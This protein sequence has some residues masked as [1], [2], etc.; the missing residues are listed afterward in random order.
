[1][2]IGEFQTIPHK[3][4]YSA[5]RYIDAIKIC[6]NA[7]IE[8]VII[9]S[10]THVWQ[11]Q[12]GVLEYQNRLGGRYQDWMKA[13]PVYQKWLD[14]I[15]QSPAHIICTIRKKQAYNLIQ[16]GQK[17]K[18][19]KAGL[20]DQIRDGFDFEMTIALEIINDTHMARSAKDRTGLFSDKP[21]FIVTVETGKKILEWCNQGLPA[22]PID[23]EFVKTI[24]ACT[25]YNQ[26]LSLY[27]NNPDKKTTHISHFNRRKQEVAPKPTET[28]FS[29]NNFSSNGTTTD[30]Q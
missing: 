8:V 28:N 12:G 22:L 17:T 25:T 16:D 5:Q 23:D 9:D 14:A 27:V 19:E 21:E 1:M 20:D 2:F 13:T 7:G 10:V 6:E 18:V 11:G 26:L 4:P 30:K 24:N 15:L 3:P 29:S